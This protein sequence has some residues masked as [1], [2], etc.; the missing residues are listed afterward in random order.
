MEIVCPN[1][2]AAYRLAP[3]AIGPEG[4]KVRCARCGQEWLA[5]R[6]FAQ[7]AMEYA[8]LPPGTDAALTAS[9]A[10]ALLIEDA[11]PL[12]TNGSARINP[13]PPRRRPP[14]GRQAVEIDEEEEEDAFPDVPTQPSAATREPPPQPVRQAALPVPVEPLTIAAIGPGFERIRKAAASVAKPAK[15]KAPPRRPLR[16]RMGLPALGLVVLLVGGALLARQAIVSAVPDLAGLYA[17]LGLDVNLRG[18]EFRNM[19]AIRDIENGR[20][21]L[22]VKGEIANLSASDAPVP[23]IRLALRSGTQEIYAWSVDS[24]RRS[25]AAGETAQFSTRLPTPPP[26]AGDIEVRFTK[27]PR[28]AASVD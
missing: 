5:T 8:V 3:G 9:F 18:L 25:L 1:C 6:T 20:P 11:E 13:R 4:R 17:L 23:P 26:G 27:N 16:E 14:P 15:R 10:D 28:V 7:P 19:T 24:P 2:A 22:I 12:A 21:V